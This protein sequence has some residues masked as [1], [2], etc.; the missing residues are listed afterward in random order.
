M[1]FASNVVS[2]EK[3]KGTW[4]LLFQDAKDRFL[5]LR[6]VFTGNGQKTPRISAL[7]VYYPR[8]SY[9]ENY[10]PSIYREDE[11]SASFLDRFLANFEGFYTSIEDRISVAQML[12][13]VRSA[14]AETLEWL[15]GWFG[16]IFDPN[17]DDAKR[18][19]FI[20]RA[21][22]FYQFRGTMRGLRAALHLALYP[23]ADD[24]IFESQTSEQ[25][26]LDP[27]RI[28]ERFQTRRTPQII[29]ADFVTEKNKPRVV[30][31]TEKWKPNQGAD[32][33]HQ[34]YGKK[35]KDDEDKK[36][37]LMKPEKA[38]EAAIWESFALEVFGFLPSG[39][40][41]VE[42]KQWQ[43]FLSA[44]Y[45]GVIGN[46]NQA[47]GKNYSNFANVFLPDGTETKNELKTDWKKYVSETSASSRNRRLWQDFLARRYRRIGQLNQIYGTNWD[48]FEFVSLFDQLPPANQ[49]L[50]DWFLFESIVLAMHQTAHRFTVLIPANIGGQKPDTLEQQKT[51]LELVRR[52]VELE[53]PAHTVFD[54]RYY[55]NLFR[56]EEVRLGLDT[57]LGLGSRDPLLSPELVIGENFVGESRIGFA[58]PEKYPI[59]YVLGNENLINKQKEEEKK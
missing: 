25:R 27:I 29:P 12:F 48:S 1:P 57:L 23:C 2:K 35:F 14:P 47:H 46:L 59:R 5:Q 50:A 58:Q 42:Q 34:R 26:K 32:V 22:D 38:E 55:W 37:S 19:L 13:D 56:L 7:R 31:Q 4:E 15:A 10:L 45:A 16:I 11:R 54:F 21:I 20:K 28:V 40:A 44:E 17:W 9:S 24:S 52:V 43:G 18:R 53:K 41:E 33:L 3:G 51:K 49:P 30:E 8:F 39:A 36:F 6:L